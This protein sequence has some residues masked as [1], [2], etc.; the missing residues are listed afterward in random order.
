MI[1]L[2]FSADDYGLSVGIYWFVIA[3]ILLIA[4]VIIQYRVFKGKMDDVGY[5]EH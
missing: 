2:S 3:L 5:G 4:Y 1:N